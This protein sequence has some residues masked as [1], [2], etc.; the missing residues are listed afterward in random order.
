LRRVIS[1]FNRDY[2]SGE[3]VS[4]RYLLI[5]KRYKVTRGKDGKHSDV[6]TRATYEEII[7]IGHDLKGGDMSQRD[8]KKRKRKRGK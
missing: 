7:C 8:D 4:T 5:E 6:N 1:G 2:I 3:S